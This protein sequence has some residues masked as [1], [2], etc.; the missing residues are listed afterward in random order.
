MKK[1]FG[2]NI[3]NGVASVKKFALKG[4]YMK[5]LKQLY[6][7]LHGFKRDEPVPW[8]PKNWVA[9]RRISN[10]ESCDSRDMILEPLLFK[11]AWKEIIKRYGK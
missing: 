7:K 9:W 11:L 6:M 2:I 4:E 8:L 3:G 10:M 5:K 1:C